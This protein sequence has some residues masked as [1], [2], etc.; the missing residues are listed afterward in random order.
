MA[1]TD[2]TGR[3]RK[4]TRSKDA[5]K[6]AQ[7][8]K[9]RIGKKAIVGYFSPELSSAVHMIA[10]SESTKIQALVGEALDLLLASRGQSAFHER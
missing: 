8:A 5:P 2:A 1:S 6:T 7:R 9:A 4:A 10:I 3:R